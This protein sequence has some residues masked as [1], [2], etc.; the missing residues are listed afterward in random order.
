MVTIRVAQNDYYAASVTLYDT[1]NIGV[2]LTGATAIV[3]DLIDVDTMTTASTVACTPVVGVQ[4]ML[5]M[6]LTPT[7]TSAKKM[8]IVAFH[9]YG[10]GTDVV[11]YPV[12]GEQ[13]LWVH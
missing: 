5:S 3:A 12:T 4:G 9:V 8:Y 10:P 6:P 1:S 7:Q 2:V 13:G 11:T